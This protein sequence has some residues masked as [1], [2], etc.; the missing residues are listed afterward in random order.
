MS[1]FRERLSLI[2]FVVGSALGY[3]W[4][5]GDIQRHE[6]LSLIGCSLLLMGLY[7]TR[8]HLKL[9]H[10][11]ILGLFFRGL[12]IF[13]SPELSQ[14]FYRFFWDGHLQKLGYS[15]Y[16]QTPNQWVDQG[17]YF[18]GIELLHQG[19]GSLSA[20]HFSNYP[21]LSQYLFRIAVSTYHTLEGQILIF[22]LL[23]LGADLALFW[24]GIRVLQTL[25]LSSE[26]IGW[27]FLNPLIIIEG[28][29]NL[30]FEGVMWAFFVWGL[31]GSLR[32]KTIVWSG[33]AFGASIATK[34]LPLIVLP[35]YWQR[36]GLKKSIGLG[37]IVGLV[38]LLL[39][40]PFWVEAGAN[41]YWETLQLWFNRFEFNGSIYNVVRW[42]GYQT[43]G[44]NIIRQLGQVTPWILM[45][46][47]GV[48]TFLKNNRTTQA[49]FRNMLWV[50]TIYLCMATT[51]H[52]WYLSSLVLMSV[53]TGYL[54]PLLWSATV[55][56]SYTAY[57]IDSFNESDWILALEYIPF[58]GLLVY[59]IFKGPVRD[60]IM[61]RRS[62]SL[63]D[64]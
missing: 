32:Y 20:G 24:G 42:I 50:L 9:H 18:K 11:L 34:L 4:F 56:F 29:G 26:S 28:I 16:A 10:I 45:G 35:L 12:F 44:Y 2:L 46:C 25:R 36:L 57:G 62:T 58:Y 41:N 55:F 63:V 54:Y 33:L 13:Y 17:L 37:M 22:R 5:V 7:A 8:P 1:L 38:C 49:L 51:V 3:L 48:F 61:W 14:D 39:S 31:Y 21:P 53:F 15:P 59:E 64:K 60:Q 27:Y 47:I 30:H 43:K 19:M 52:P 40:L 23:L 6:H